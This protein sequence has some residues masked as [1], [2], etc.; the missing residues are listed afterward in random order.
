[1]CS[2]LSHQVCG[3]LSEQLQETN[4]P[5]PAPSARGGRPAPVWSEPTQ[6]PPGLPLS[7]LS[8]AVGSPCNCCL[9]LSQAVQPWKCFP[10]SL[11]HLPPRGP[12]PTTALRLEERAHRAQARLAQLR[13]CRYDQYFAK[14]SGPWRME[15]VPT[16]S[17]MDAQSPQRCQAIRSEHRLLDE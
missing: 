9:H 3:N 7:Q 15:T 1:M 13:V 2:I 17:T 10:A 8:T 12:S 14:K 5:P 4:A 11:C 6:V 16:L